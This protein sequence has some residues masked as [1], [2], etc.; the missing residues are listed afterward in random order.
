MVRLLGQGLADE[1]VTKRPG[2]PRTAQRMAADLLEMLGAPSRFQASA[3]WRE[4]G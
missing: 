2:G 4:A 3:P 1:A